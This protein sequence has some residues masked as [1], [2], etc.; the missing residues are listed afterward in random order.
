M[1]QSSM[2]KELLDDLTSICDGRPCE[3]DDSP[4]N[5]YLCTACEVRAYLSSARQQFDHAI[6]EN[7]NALKAEM[8]EALKESNLEG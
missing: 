3:C 2:F 6:R 4:D 7:L 5:R 8:L 1:S